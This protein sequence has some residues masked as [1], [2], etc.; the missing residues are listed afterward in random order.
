MFLRI[1]LL[2]NYTKP[3]SKHYLVILAKFLIN[4]N[5]FFGAL[6]LTTLHAATLRALTYVIVSALIIQNFHDP[7]FAVTK[8]I[9]EFKSVE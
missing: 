1:I 9:F 6:L 4:Y 8:Y 5:I 7:I 2:K 3:E